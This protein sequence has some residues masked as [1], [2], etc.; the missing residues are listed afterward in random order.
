MGLF[1]KLN[2]LDY[3]LHLQK[4]SKDSVDI[5]PDVIVITMVP[6]HH[7]S[8]DD[9][10]AVLTSNFFPHYINFLANDAHIVRGG[11]RGKSAFKDSHFMA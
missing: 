10:F 3:I 5:S 1:L 8:T 4:S 9:I 2:F 7:F 6:F 11:G